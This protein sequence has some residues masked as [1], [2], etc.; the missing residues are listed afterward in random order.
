MIRKNKIE[1]WYK[2]W[3]SRKRA[4][5]PLKEKDF[6]KQSTFAFDAVYTVAMALNKTIPK[7]GRKFLI[8]H[9][10]YFCVIL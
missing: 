5:K 3:K 10:V 4:A 7:Q 1:I 2:Y 8:I 6:F 9:L